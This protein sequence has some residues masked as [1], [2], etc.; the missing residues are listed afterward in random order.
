MP[1]GGKGS[2]P[3]R[4]VASRT[5]GKC[6]VCHKFF[7]LLKHIPAPGEEEEEDENEAQEPTDDDDDDDDDEDGAKESA[8][9]PPQ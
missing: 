9:K 8:P 2:L 7:Q 1:K 4:V 3:P 6:F 5:G